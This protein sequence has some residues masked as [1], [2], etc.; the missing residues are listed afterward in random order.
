MYIAKFQGQNGY[1]QNLDN[2]STMDE[3]IKFLNQQIRI[4]AAYKN[5]SIKEQET[6]REIFA[7]RTI[8]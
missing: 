7:Y 5:A 8:K 2:A 6:G 4:D 1:W 3:A